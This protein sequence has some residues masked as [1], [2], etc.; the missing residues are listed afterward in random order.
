MMRQL[1]VA[2]VSFAMLAWA[3]PALALTAEDAINMAV[4][5]E[6]L[7]PD[8]QIEMETMMGTIE[9]AEGVQTIDGIEYNVVEYQDPVTG[10]ILKMIYT[11]DGQL[12]KS[13]LS[14]QNT[15]IT[16]TTEYDENGNAVAQTIMTTTE[17]G[18]VWRST[19]IQYNTDGTKTYTMIDYTESS[20][21]KITALVRAGGDIAN[22]DDIISMTV[23]TQPGMPRP[24]SES[25]CPNT[26]QSEIVV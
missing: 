4:E 16:L 12:V 10:N 1:K 13:E 3:A 5:A 15:G 17:D 21:N 14:D 7:L 11:T 6:G 18:S 20:D 9:P 26:G 8:L 22:R 23:E 2:F 25:T 19:T 24:P